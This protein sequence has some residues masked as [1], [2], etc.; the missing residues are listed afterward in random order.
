MTRVFFYDAPAK[1]CGTSSLAIT[2]VGSR[3]VFV[4]GRR[5]VR[6]GT[7]YSRY[8]EAVIIHELLHSLGLGENPSSSDH[9]TE[10]VLARCGR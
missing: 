6:Q 5:F 10:R 1:A 9:I 8:A 2:K 7:R 3:A 4:C